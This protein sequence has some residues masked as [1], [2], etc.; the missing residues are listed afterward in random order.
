MRISNQKMSLI[1]NLTLHIN[2]VSMCFTI[3]VPW[4]QQLMRKLIL[5]YLLNMLTQLLRIFN[6]I[7]A[8]Y[9]HKHDFR[10]ANAQ[11]LNGSRRSAQSRLTQFGY[12]GTLTD[13]K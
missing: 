7:E 2:K 11:I 12:R 3:A 13:K 8:Y 10:I 5:T 1:V 6:F 9:F 4:L